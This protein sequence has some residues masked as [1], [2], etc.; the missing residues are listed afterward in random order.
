MKEGEKK[1]R[2]HINLSVPGSQKSGHRASFPQPVPTFL[3]E[4]DSVSSRKVN[5]NRK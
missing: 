3:I 5:G 2:N 4:M 1:G